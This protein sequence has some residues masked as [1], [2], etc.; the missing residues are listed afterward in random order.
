MREV[1]TRILARGTTSFLHCYATN[2]GTITLYESLGFAP[3]QTVAAAVFS[4]A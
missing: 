4:S 3:F 1:A 2:A